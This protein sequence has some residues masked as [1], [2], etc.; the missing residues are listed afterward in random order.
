MCT[1]P[2]EKSLQTTYRTEHIEN[3]LYKEETSKSTYRSKE[4]VIE[5]VEDEDE[6]E[7][8]DVVGD[9]D[10]PRP[11]ILR[12]YM[13]SC[14]YETNEC[15]KCYTNCNSLKRKR[16]SMDFDSTIEGAT[17]PKR[18]VP[19][20]RI[21]ESS[22]TAT[23][24]RSEYKSFEISNN[25]SSL[26]DR[27]SAFET[28][29]KTRK[30]STKLVHDGDLD[31]INEHRKSVEET[32][33]DC[34]NRNCSELTDSDESISIPFNFPDK[35]ITSSESKLF[36]TN[37]IMYN[38]SGI[39]KYFPQQYSGKEENCLVEGRKYA[40]VKP[41]NFKNFNNFG[42]NNNK[43]F[44]KRDTEIDTDE[45]N[46]VLK[47]GTKLFGDLSI[48]NSK[49]IDLLIK[50]RQCVEDNIQKKEEIV[51]KKEEYVDDD[52]EEGDDNA[53]RS[54][55]DSTINEFAK[56]KR[57]KE[58]SKQYREKRKNA[59]KI[60][61]EKQRD[62]EQKNAQLKEQLKTMEYLNE[63]MQ[64][65]FAKKMC[66]KEKIKNEIVKLLQ[67]SDNVTDLQSEINVMQKI[68]QHVAN[69]SP[70][71][72]YVEKAIYEILGEVIKN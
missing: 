55:E 32:K 6:D 4:N 24:P 56:K 34:Y 14:P 20:R 26:R 62:L 68:F 57:N 5:A 37:G 27:S 61:F 31:S 1:D 53:I 30:D 52:E 51:V 48:G 16:L 49:K 45:S 40:I 46:F 18:P 8:I 19:Y 21:S 13:D 60:V 11:N 41:L 36:L 28:Y 29:Y 64:K 15:Y 12:C 50:E 17:S 59:I 10:T 23:S 43:S 35:T 65:L 63:T 25:E 2:K 7:F 39:E 22:S 70:K 54:D 58:A 3:I 72:G 33:E 38:K 69:E 66:S 71:Q 67:R 47:H 9:T 42:I 44:L